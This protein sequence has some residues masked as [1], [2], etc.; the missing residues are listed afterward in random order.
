MN[1]IVIIGGGASGMTAAIIAARKNKKV[2]ILEKNDKLGKKILVTGNGRCNYFNEEINISHYHSDNE[3]DLKNIITKENKEKVISFFDSLGIIPKIKNGYYYPITKEATTILNALTY[4]I[5]RLNIKVITNTEVTEIKKEDY[6][7]INPNKENIKA[8]KIIITT[9][10]KAAPKTGSDGMGYS[11]AKSLNHTI[12]DPKPALVQ[13]KG[14]GDYFNK[15]N[16]IRVEATL[17][18]HEDDKFIKEETGELQLTDY[19]ISGIVTFNLSRYIARNI[20]N[21][22]ETININFMPWLNE[23]PHKWLKKQIINLNL[24]ITETL[25][26]FL[27]Y[28]LVNIILKKSNIKTNDWNKINDKEF[29]NII[30][31][32]TK[33]EIEI[34]SVNSFDKSQICSGGIPLPEINLKT[35]ESLKTKD[36]YF[37]GEIIDIDGDCG[38]YNLGFAWISGIISGENI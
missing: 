13:L 30:K 17:S 20:N 25:E 6:F 33:F 37:A 27:N 12:I 3:E 14:K 21:H 19:G 24:P 36:L 38:G 11:L 31:N 7:I 26:R 22:K 32:L 8:K 2:T 35:M 5:K 28:K 16:G 1:D 9:G 15:W 29:S 10:S 18:L 4:E 34:E 23:D